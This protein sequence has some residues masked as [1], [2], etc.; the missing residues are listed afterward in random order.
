MLST[1][2]NLSLKIK[3]IFGFM[4]VGIITFILVD[5]I[6]V[7]TASDSLEKEAYAKLIAI[8]DN[9]KSS[10]EYYFNFIRDQ[11]ILQ[12]KHPMVVDATKAFKQHFKSYREDKQVTDDQL[13]M[14][15]AKIKSYYEDKFNVEFKNQ[16]NGQSANIDQM[17]KGLDKDSIALQYAYISNNHFP[18][19]EKD[20]LDAAKDETAYSQYHAKFHPV[21]RDFLNKNGYYDIFLLDIDSGDIV[22]SVFKELDYSTSLINGPYASTNFAEAFRKASKMTQADDYVLVDFK[23]YGPSYDA[24]AS[25]IASPIFDGDKKIGVMIF[26]MPLD[27]IT[28]VMSNRAGLGEKGESYLVGSDSL[29]RSDS[30]LDPKKHSVVNSFRYPEKNKLNSETVTQALNNKTGQQ[31]IINYLNDPVFSAYTP[32]TIAGQVTW[33]L[34]S[35]ASIKEALYPVTEL[36]NSMFKLALLILILIS[37]AAYFLANSVVKPI[38]AAVAVANHIANND[39]DNKINITSKDETGQ[40]LQSLDTMQNNLRTSIENEKQKLVEAARLKSGLDNVNTSVMIA[41]NDRKIIYMNKSVEN[42]LRTATPELRKVIPDF[43]VDKV[44]GTNIDQYHKNPANQAK[45][46][47]SLNGSHKARIN[48][49]NSILDLTVSPVMNDEVGHIGSVVEWADSTD[50]VSAMNKL[51]ELIQGV[52]EGVLNQRFDSSKMNDELIANIG[53]KINSMLDG[54]TS[55][56]ASLSENTRQVANAAEQSS[57]A[58]GQISDGSQQ[59][60]NSIDQMA[61]HIS[62]TQTAIAD[63]SHSTGEASHEADQTVSIVSSGSE[64]MTEMIASING[65]KQSSGDILKITEVIGNIANQTNMLSLNAAIEAARAGEQGKG[66]AVV[67][68]EVRKLAE[69]VA[70][71]VLDISTLINETVEKI[72]SGVEISSSVKMDMDTMANHVQNV[73][74]MLNRIAAAMEQQNSTIVN[75]GDNAESLRH[76][77][78]NNATASEE[79]TSTIID[80]SRIAN[81]TN[82]VLEKYQF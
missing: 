11:I 24:P 50:S 2:K 31:T 12:S 60:A 67:A 62:E 53:N 45:L 10:I 65:I 54:F 3:L 72:D 42:L 17:L 25:F 70:S 63:V 55:L 34:I 79:M 18:L 22:Y 19:G 13:K 56:M 59:Q 27:R 8:R 7:N 64:K 20:K 68:D 49:G 32:I 44:M 14:M 41:D 37:I 47:E 23:T 69:N 16:N 40:L 80:L 30:F 58:I 81:D 75:L 76:I 6:A 29:M 78:E 66:F 74:G 73:H 33:A 77:A 21:M 71:S 4:L 28:Q 39:L 1:L 36:K 48:V 35:E 46:L 38:L 15:K 51:E 26:Q 52:N 82:D 61:N 5:L 57:L 9:K 43:N